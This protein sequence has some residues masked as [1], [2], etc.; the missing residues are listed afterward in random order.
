MLQY[1]ESYTSNILIS[2]VSFKHVLG[3]ITNRSLFKFIAASNLYNARSPDS[4]ALGREKEDLERMSIIPV[5]FPN[6]HVLCHK[7]RNVFLI[8]LPWSQ[9]SGSKELMAYNMAKHLQG[10]PRVTLT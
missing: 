4:K 3:I 1:T 10:S 2:N 9:I 7:E 5:Q 6:G 8:L